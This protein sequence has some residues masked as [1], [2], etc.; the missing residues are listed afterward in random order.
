MRAAIGREYRRATSFP[1]SE[2]DIRRWAMAIYYPEPPPP[3][4]WD[5]DYARGTR[6]G[7]VIAP[8]EFNPFAWMRAAPRSDAEAGGFLPEASLGVEP[9]N[10][11]AVIITSTEL[12]YG[13]PPMRPG[14]VISASTVLQ[15]YQERAGRRGLMLSTFSRE[16]WRNQR[17]EV[18][19]TND[20]VFVRF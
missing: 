2:S 10:T 20:T 7:G 8:E 11:R 4:F 18:V 14:D 6:W 9:P 16:T 3:L 5:A 15:D 17:D 12:R 1:I 19:R 13:E